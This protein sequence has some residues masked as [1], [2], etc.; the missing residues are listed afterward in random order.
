MWTSSLFNQIIFELGYSSYL[1]LGVAAGN[2][3]NNVV[4]ESKTGV[5]STNDTMW[6]LNDVLSKTT[7]EYFQS[8]E[9]TST[10][11]DLVY[12]DACHEKYQV[13]KDFCNSLNH[14]NSCGMV[15]FHDIYPLRKEDTNI[16][17]GNGN[18]YEFWIE[19][20]NH[21]NDQTFVIEGEPEH[22]EGTVGIYLNPDKNFNSNLIVGIDHSYEYFYDNVDKYIYGKKMEQN[23]FILRCKENVK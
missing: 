4:C 18:V 10:K 7:D 5:D 19:L 1:E 17:T 15:V 14:L 13:Y 8:I 11:F 6:H 21:Y 22:P 2:C 3:W 12:I 23:E 16:Q 9:N 20:V